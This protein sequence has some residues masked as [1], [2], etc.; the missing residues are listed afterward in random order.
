MA[1]ATLDRLASP[2]MRR[3]RPPL[4]LAAILPLALLAAAC[5]GDDDDGE[6]ARTAFGGGSGGL[7]TVSGA[8][9]AL[10]AGGSGSG[11][12]SDSAGSD[13]GGDVETIGWGDL[14]RAAG[15]AELEVPDAA[16]SDAVVDYLQVLTNGR[17][18]ADTASPVLVLPPADA[19]AERIAEI[20]DFTAEVGWNVL[21]VARFVERQTAPDTLTVIEG[22]IEEGAL[23]EAMGDP[24]A[25]GLWA[26][27]DPEAEDFETDLDGIT[28]ARPLGQTLWMGFDGDLLRVARSRATAERAVSLEGGTLADDEVY[29]GLAAGLDEAEVYGALLVTPG[30]PM[31]AAAGLGSPEQAERAC[32]EALPQPTTGVAT[33]IAEDGGPVYVVT[34]AHDAPDAAEANAAAIEQIV[35][36]G[37]SLVSGQAWSD[38]VTLDGVEVTGDGQVVV[39]RLRPVESGPPALW[40]QM[41]MQRDSL[42]TSC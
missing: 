11:G 18:D 17:V 31:D 40:Y 25:D 7:D 10:P 6:A 30:M 8:L 14:E 13:S 22:S 41:V 19:G 3:S 16:D 23:T 34:L 20:E 4:A 37:T 24:V 39:A 5:G 9:A 27:G 2:A 35:T 42:V 36:E 29:A 38:L 21:D 28:V 1:A 12:G 33:G 15:I 32:Q 26:A